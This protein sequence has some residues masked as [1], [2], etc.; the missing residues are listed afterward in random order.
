[1]LTS[2]LPIMRELL[3][4]KKNGRFDFRSTDLSIAMNTMKRSSNR[5][6][7]DYELSQ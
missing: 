6:T 2:Y 1:M 3:K 7:I 5:I 4:A